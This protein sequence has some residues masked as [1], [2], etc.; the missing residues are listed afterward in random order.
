MV[1][2]L[3]GCSARTAYTPVNIGTTGDMLALAEGHIST[4]L[5]DWLGFQRH[6]IVRSMEEVCMTKNITRT[7]WLMSCPC[8]LPFHSHVLPGNS[9]IPES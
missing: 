5:A 7:W 6:Y 9:I 4:T 1:Y 3:A 8:K 2:L